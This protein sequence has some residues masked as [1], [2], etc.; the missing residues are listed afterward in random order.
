MYTYTHTISINHSLEK[1]QIGEEVGL[2]GGAFSHQ[3]LQGKARAQP[4]AAPVPPG[5]RLTLRPGVGPGCRQEERQAEAAAEPERRH[6]RAGPPSAAAAAA[7]AAAGVL[8]GASPLG[9]FPLRSAVL[10][11]SWIRWFYRLF[12]LTQS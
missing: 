12:Y 6:G 5:G 9:A 4:G 10:S 2:L 8:P 1:P 3:G 11:F 7:V